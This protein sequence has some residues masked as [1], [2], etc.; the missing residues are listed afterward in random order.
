MKQTNAIAPPQGLTRDERQSWWNARRLTQ[1]AENNATGLAASAHDY[2]IVHPTK[3]CTGTG[4]GTAC[5]AC[6]GLGYL[7]MTVEDIRAEYRACRDRVCDANPRTTEE[8]FHEATRVWVA[9]QGAGRDGP[10]YY[11]AAA[12]AVETK[13]TRERLARRQET[14][15][16]W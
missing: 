9:R 6:R 2:F 4:K 7:P 10:G 8:D 15:S 1:S 16:R 14:R 5:S 13:Y 3:P 11:L 12:N